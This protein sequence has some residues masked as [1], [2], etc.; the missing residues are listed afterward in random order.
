[1]QAPD[2]GRHSVVFEAIGTPWRIETNAVISG[3]LTQAVNTEIESFDHEYSRFRADSLVTALANGAHSQ[4]FTH[5]VPELFGLYDTLH[6]L[7]CGKVTPLIGNTLANLGYDADYSLTNKAAK[8][9]KDYTV[10]THEQQTISLTEPALIDIGAAGKGYL[11][12]R[13]ASLIESQHDS[14]VVDG[15]GDILV[16]GIWQT[17]GL[18][19]PNDPNRVIGHIELTNGALCGSASN[20]RAWGQGLHHIVDGTTGLP[21]QNIHAT[22]VV[23]DTAMVADGLATA[24]FFTSPDILATAFDFQFVLMNK[25]GSVQYSRDPGITVYD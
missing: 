19:H 4:T 24:L 10:L 1:M 7:T 13:V 22:W 25:D 21:T 15:S 5:G 14:F 2:S 18:E 3:A 9:V 8:P 17:I 12:D 6:Q 20:R 11:I 23:A 16:H